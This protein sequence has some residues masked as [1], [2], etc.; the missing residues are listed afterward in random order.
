MLEDEERIGCHVALTP[1]WSET[2]QWADYVLPMGLGARAARPD[3][4]G[5][6]RG[7]LDR[8][9]PAGA[10]RVRAPEG[11][12]RGNARHEPGRGLGG[13]RVL[14][15]PHLAHRPDG[16]LGHPQVLRVEASA[17]AAHLDGRVLRRHLRALGAG[18]ARGGG[19]AEGLKPLEYMRRYGA[20]DV[21]Y[22]GRSATRPRPPR[23]ASSSRTARRAGF[24]T[25][26]GRLEFYSPTLTEWGR[27]EHARSR[28]HPLPGALAPARPR[29]ASA[30]SCRPSACRP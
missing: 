13:G 14:D 3:E 8:L 6:P 15:R 24:K 1:I 7:H 27:G 22:A 18:P 17:R 16:E 23:T 9:P 25:P 12:E 28:L 30:A 19:E 29:G 5:D 20:F 21:P 11:G 26:S 4:P 10:A 2:A